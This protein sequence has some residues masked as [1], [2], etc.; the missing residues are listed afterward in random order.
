MIANNFN[1]AQLNIVC[2]LILICLTSA[3][4]K[5]SVHNLLA[6]LP[7]QDNYIPKVMQIAVSTEIL[8]QR[9]LQSTRN[10]CQTR[11]SVNIIILIPVP[12]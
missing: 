7:L 2:V 1:N 10:V 5:N 4:Y 12:R 8:T 11:V 9:I 6:L 3:N